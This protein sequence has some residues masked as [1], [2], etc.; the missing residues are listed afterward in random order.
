MMHF[1][2]KP[3]ALTEQSLLS[4]ATLVAWKKERG[5]YNFKSLPSTAIIGIEKNIF[6]SQLNLFSKKLKGLRGNNYISDAFVFCSGFGSGAPAIVTLLEEL[7]VLGVE[8]FIFIGLAG[9]LSDNIKTGDAFCVDEALSGSGTTSYY[10]TESLIH[11]YDPEFV[12]DIAHS[13]SL[14]MTCCFSTDSPFRETPS[15]IANVKAKGCNMIEMEC[16]AI[17]AFSQYYKLKAA[18]ILL[19]ADVLAEVWTPPAQHINLTAKQ[20][21][22]VTTLT[23][24]LR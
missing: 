23:K 9:I 5:I 21:E 3:E 12:Q 11:P 2:T 4:A 15:L 17:Y 16:A 22:L 20:Q 24:S 6:S 13:V 1:I 10:A 18:C 19:A 8:Q 7:R 14:K